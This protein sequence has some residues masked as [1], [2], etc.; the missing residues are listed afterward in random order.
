MNLSK[1]PV[2]I[3]GSGPGGYVAAL[4]LAQLGKAVTLIEKAAL[5]GTCL[6]EGC[7][8]SK[9]LLESS[10]HFAGVKNKFKIHGI[11]TPEV[12]LD[13]AALMARK[14]QVV[15]T[16]RRGLE[17][18]LKKNQI[19]VVRGR[20]SFQGDDEILVR[21][22]TGEQ[23]LN[24]E[25]CILATGSRAT[26]PPNLKLEGERVL[27]S[28]E[29][30]NLTQLPQSLLILGAGVIGLE[31]GSVYSRLGTR[32]EIIEM[33]ERP[34]AEMDGEVSKELLRCLKKQG[35]KFHL[36]CRATA[37][38]TDIEGARLKVKNKKGQEVVLSGEKILVATG[39]GP[40]T[41]GLGLDK[42]GVAITP[43]GFVRVNQALQT[44]NPR[45]FAIGD[46]IGGDMLAH[47]AS[48]EGAQ[49]AEILAGYLEGFTP[50]PVPL[51]IYTSPEAAS[52]GETEEALIQGQLPYKKGFFPLRPLGR[53]LASGELDGFAKIL[54]NAE[55]KVLGVHLVGERATDLIGQ[56]SLAVELGLSLEEIQRAMQPHPSY[57]ESFKEAALQALGRNHHL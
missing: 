28:T 50:R 11:V 24:F 25:H 20:A 39:R 8:P 54:S 57:S 15:A 56:G 41:Q 31:L 2:L 10:K 37:L 4:R 34:L 38:E 16:N 14:Q 1:P 52:V 9:A 18:L 42:A 7:I 47:K 6:N 17:F 21:G 53:S 45:V 35:I 51:V 29:A 30:L 19:Q 27:T 44:T 23:T 3:I 13:F 40:N 36:S 12:F 48:E 32:V 43:R 22:E 55:G 26:A 33:R 5:G 46:L 49:V